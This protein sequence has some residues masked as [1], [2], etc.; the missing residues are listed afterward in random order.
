MTSETILD[1]VKPAS[2]HHL[3]CFLPGIC[4]SLKWLFIY[5]CIFCLA[6]WNVDSRRAG[7][8]ASCLLWVAVSEPGPG[9]SSNATLRSTGQTLGKAYFW[10]GFNFSENLCEYLGVGLDWKA[11]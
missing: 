6:S 5:L 10:M 11:V 8:W 3:V 2:S 4:D 9:H 1:P 7:P